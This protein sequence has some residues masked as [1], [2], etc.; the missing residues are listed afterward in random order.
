MITLRIC[1]AKIFHNLCKMWHNLFNTVFFKKSSEFFVD[2]LSIIGVTLCFDFLNMLTNISVMFF[3]DFLGMLRSCFCICFY[4]VYGMC[5]Q[6]IRSNNEYDSKKTKPNAVWI[7]F[8]YPK[9]S[10]LMIRTFSDRKSNTIRVEQS[11]MNIC[12]RLRVV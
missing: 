6:S 5:Y 7:F 11:Q 12:V 4:V 1:F 8:K 9:I 3:C 2:F 10:L